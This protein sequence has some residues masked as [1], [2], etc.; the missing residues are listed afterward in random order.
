MEEV[1]NEILD[2]RFEVEDLDDCRAKI[3]YSYHPLFDGVFDRPWY[4]DFEEDENGSLRWDAV[5]FENCD[6]Q[7]GEVVMSG[8][9]VDKKFVLN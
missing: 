3:N 4:L 8:K 7:H 9:I 5:E 2:E 1:I 6:D